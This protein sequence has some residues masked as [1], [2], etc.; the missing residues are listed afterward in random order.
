MKASRESLP[1]SSVFSHLQIMK[2]SREP[3]LGAVGSDDLNADQRGTDVG[4]NRT[5]RSRLQ[6]L[7]LARHAQVITSE[8][9]AR[10]KEG[11]RWGGRGRESE[12]GRWEARVESRGKEES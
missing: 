7:H 2:A 4:E 12:R 9:E 11:E 10:R 5:S 3:F 1:T 6:T 8:G